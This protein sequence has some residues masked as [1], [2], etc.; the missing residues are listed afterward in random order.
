MT[1]GEGQ[2][3]GPFVVLNDVLLRRLSDPAE[4]DAC[5][6]GLRAC[7]ERPFAPHQGRYGCSVRAPRRDA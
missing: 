3:D 6:A 4:L 1:Q 7:Y 5:R 2:V